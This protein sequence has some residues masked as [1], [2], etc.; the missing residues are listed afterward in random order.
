MK[1]LK[2][3]I[4]TAIVLSVIF[5][6][7]FACEKDITVELPRA[8][9]KLNVQAY[10]ELD[11]F[12]IVFLTKNTSYFDPIDTN[13][14]K[15][16]IIWGNDANVTV[17]CNGII[18]TLIPFKNGQMWP[19]KGYIGTKIKGQIGNSYRLDIKYNNKEFFSTT[20]ILDTVG[21]DSVKYTS[22][23]QISV[24][25]GKKLGYLTIYWK[26]NPMNEHFAIRT[27][28]PSQKWFYRPMVVNVIDD[29]LND[30]DP[31]LSCPYLTKGYERNSYYAASEDDN[32]TTS[33]LDHIMFYPLD[34]VEIK[35]STIDDEAFLFW[36][37]IDRSKMTD[38]NP[39]VNPASV[40]SNIKG[41][42]AVGSWI[43][44]GSWAGKYFI[45]TTNASKKRN[46]S[47]VKL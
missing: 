30:N 40:K 39:F 46:Y 33:F 20:T 36:Q 21:I 37:S 35:L 8:E 1:L 12:P 25:E 22:L 6:G 32:D 24:A 27:K 23:L 38:G 43:G 7:F 9:E 13:K 15:D 17:T 3:H 45:D 16:L 19:Y 41:A 34:T 26:N 14:I 18:D 10:I 42:P 28:S 4:F 44:Y 11:E 29:K 5:I 2:K 31:F 47:V